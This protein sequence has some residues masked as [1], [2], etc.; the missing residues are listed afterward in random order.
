MP[1]DFEYFRIARAFDDAI[2]LL[3]TDTDCPNYLYE[4]TAIENPE[5]LLFQ[6]GDPIPIKPKMGDYLSE[7]ASVISKKI[8]DVLAPLNISTIQL[9]PARIRGKNDEI[10]SN[11]WAI[12][13]LTEIKCV[14]ASLS[15]CEIKRVRLAKVKKIVLDKNILSA[16]PLP[17]R[18]VFRLQEDSSFQLYHSS[19][20]EKI[21]AANPS[22]VRF[23][24]IEE[25]NDSSFFPKRD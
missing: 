5:P 19:I 11:Y 25:W 8:F 3:N 18:L 17:E 22:G 2:P 20:V 9:L 10:F 21:L 7:P 12:H 23:V 6:L 16:I 1:D 15:N 24:N 14:D 4:Q 13:M